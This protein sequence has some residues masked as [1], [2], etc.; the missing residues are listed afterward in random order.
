MVSDTSMEVVVG[1]G[2]SQE[3]WLKAIPLEMSWVTAES[4][5]FC[6]VGYIPDKESWGNEYN[7]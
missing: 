2:A 6:F 5:D 7:V 3:L 1:A 4:V